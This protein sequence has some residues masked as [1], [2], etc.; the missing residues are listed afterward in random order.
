MSLLTPQQQ[1]Q[2]QQQHMQMQMQ[3]GRLPFQRGA[4]ERRPPPPSVLRTRHVL[5][6]FSGAFTGLEATLR[7]EAA[8]REATTPLEPPPESPPESPSAPPSGAPTDVLQLAGTSDLVR[9]GLEPEFVGR[10]PVR[11][12]CRHLDAADLHRVL[13]DAKDSAWAQLQRDF[14]GYGIEIAISECG[15]REVAEIAVRE[16]TGARGLLTVLERTLRSF[17]FELPGRGVRAVTVDAATVRDPGAHLR[18]LLA[19]GDH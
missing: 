19:E 3:R 12:A 8:Q 6:V 9:C 15:L 5:F 17:K 2:Q 18:A 4:A 7:R 10:V 16:R 1:Q 14:A 11:V 13:R